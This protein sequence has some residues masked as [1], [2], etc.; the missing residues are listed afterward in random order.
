MA[1]TE[2]AAGERL[3]PDP[4]GTRVQSQLIGSDLALNVSRRR[5]G[6]FDCGDGLR[7]F[8][9]NRGQAR[10]DQ[11]LTGSGR[12]VKEGCS[13]MNRDAVG[14]PEFEHGGCNRM[15]PGP[16]SRTAAKAANAARTAT[17]PS[18]FWINHITNGNVVT[19]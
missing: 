5:V 9:E 15:K 6:Q 3:N 19:S 1:E 16:G 7:S 10:I 14:E 17:P 11:M 13:A 8:L 2:Y 4:E 12:L 18:R